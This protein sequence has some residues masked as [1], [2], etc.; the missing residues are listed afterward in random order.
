MKKVVSGCVYVCV[1]IKRVLNITTDDASL[2]VRKKRKKSCF[3][4]KQAEN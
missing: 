1:N 4:N 2:T 3:V